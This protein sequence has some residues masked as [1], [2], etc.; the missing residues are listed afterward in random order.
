[1][2]TIGRTGFGGPAANTVLFDCSTVSGLT[3]S[4]GTGGSVTFDS[5]MPSPRSSAG[6]V[7]ML[8]PTVSSSFVQFTRTVSP[9]QNPQQARGIGVWVKI[10]DSDAGA[11]PATVTFGVYFGTTPGDTSGG[12]ATAIANVS[13]IRNNHWYFIASPISAVSYGGGASAASWQTLSVTQIVVTRSGT[14]G[15]VA[16]WCGGVE[17]CYPARPKLLLAFDGEYVSIRDYVK[18]LMDA[19]GLIGTMFVSWSVVG[20][21][22]RMSLSDLVSLVSSGWDLGPRKYADSSIGYDNSGTYPT[23]ESIVSDIQLAQQAC[24]RAGGSQIG[25]LAQCIPSTNPWS[26]GNSFATRARCDAAFTRAGVLAARLGTPVGSGVGNGISTNQY[27]ETG[28]LGHLP[29]VYSRQLHDTVTTETALADVDEAIRLGSTMSHYMHE[30][31]AAGS[32]GVWSEANALA[33]LNGVAD[34]VRKGLIDVVTWGDWLR[35]VTARRAQV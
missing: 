23:V 11:I 31:A 35:D 4:V 2:A 1:M 17:L 28:S 3:I 29:L 34:R 33:Y 15:E 10:M 8:Q 20:S 13:G 19:R 16:F 14:A 26:G 25:S 18:P 7:R 30:T 24:I 22:G 27:S 6:S 5:Q 12:F 21:G 32:N 9:V